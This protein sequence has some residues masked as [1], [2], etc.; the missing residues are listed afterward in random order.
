MA[1]RSI[2]A[3]LMSVSAHPRRFLVAY[4]GSPSSQRALDAAADLIG[5]GSTLAVVSVRDPGTAD[6]ARIVERAREHLLKRQIMAHYMEPFGKPAE[7]I[8][9][10]ARVVD[11]DIV[12]VGRR[13]GDLR[14]VIGSVSAEVVRQAPC[15]VLVVR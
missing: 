3:T 9:E 10:A 14:R 5:Y 8:V 4:D 2:H 15:D 12:V 11:A 6:E 7:E 1:P 13:R